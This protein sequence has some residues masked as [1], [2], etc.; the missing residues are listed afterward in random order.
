MVTSNR[1]RLQHPEIGDVI[2]RDWQAAGLRL[3]SVVRTGP[4]LVLEHRS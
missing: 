2:I 4:L 3:Q 1:P